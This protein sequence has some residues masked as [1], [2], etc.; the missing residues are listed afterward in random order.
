MMEPEEEERYQTWVNRIAKHEVSLRI[1]GPD[2]ID[3]TLADLKES[4]REYQP[5][6]VIVDGMH[7][8]QSKGQSMVEQ[9]Y[10][11]S[12]AFKQMMLAQNCMGIQ[13]LHVSRS[14][15]PKPGE[16]AIKI[17]GLGFSSWGAAPSQDT[18]YYVE[19]V[20]PEGK[21]AAS[22]LAVIEKSRNDKMG[23]ARFWMNFD[24]MCFTGDIDAPGTR[25]L[26]VKG[27]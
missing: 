6:L 9:T 14:A 27:G 1:I 10:L 21:D 3:F 22:R 25:P 20:A 19:L 16:K 4:I 12:R 13:T 23:E 7:L 17:G 5:D 11:R 8:L 26:S 15:E 24:P 18:D 2:N